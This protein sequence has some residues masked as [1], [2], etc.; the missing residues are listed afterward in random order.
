MPEHVEESHGDR[1]LDTWF[2]VKRVLRLPAYRRLLA[3]YT[4][5]ELAWSVGS[6]AL[7]VL[8]YRRT[9]SAVGAMAFF[10]CSQFFPALIS[11]AVV[12]RLDQRARS[13][14]RPVGK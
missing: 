1:T 7:A 13:E 5:N 8:V 3:A 9:G 4:L 14:E 12:A 11:P 2:L 10:L 6:L